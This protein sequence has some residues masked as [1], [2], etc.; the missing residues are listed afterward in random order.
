MKHI[1]GFTI[2]ACSAFMLGLASAPAMAK[3]SDNPKQATEYPDSTRQAPKLDLTSPKEQKE[4][5]EGLDAINKGD[6]TTGQ[7]TLQDVLDKSKSSNRRWCSMSACGNRAKAHRH[8]LRQ[9]NR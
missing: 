2:L 1:R 9:K 6:M 8:Y 7:T 3:H 5:Q 4:I